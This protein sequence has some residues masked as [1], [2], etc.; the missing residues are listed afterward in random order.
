MYHLS[1]DTVTAHSPDMHPLSHSQ[2]L[3]PGSLRCC[4]VPSARQNHRPSGLNNPL[5]QV[6]CQKKPPQGGF[7]VSFVWPGR[8]IKKAEDIFRF[9]YVSVFPRIRVDTQFTHNL[10]RRFRD[11]IAALFTQV[12]IVRQRLSGKGMQERLAQQFAI[13]WRD[14][15]CSPDDACVHR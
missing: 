3:S 13:A 9:F 12:F 7:F 4:E 8:G 6:S 14:A 11:F 15:G 1:D 10:F 5:Q 2:L